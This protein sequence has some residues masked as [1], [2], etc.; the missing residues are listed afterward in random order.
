MEHFIR[1]KLNKW[2]GKDGKSQVNSSLNNVYLDL[3]FKNLYSWIE[4]RCWESV[5]E[6]SV[7]HFLVKNLWHWQNFSSET[8]FLLSLAEK[9]ISNEPFHFSDPSWKSKGH[10]V[11]SPL[12][13]W[14]EKF[15]L[16]HTVLRAWLA[17][18]QEQCIGHIC[19]ERATTWAG[20]QGSTVCGPLKAEV[21]QDDST[22]TPITKP[23]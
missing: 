13:T 23:W 9:R 4:M 8:S 11:S 15:C 22:F 19:W 14:K 5:V 10:K 3:K 12:Q 2:N 16:P 7:R 17:E 21:H 6:Q 18:R 1:W 20:T